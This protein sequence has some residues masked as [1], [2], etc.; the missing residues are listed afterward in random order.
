M[1]ISIFTFVLLL[2]LQNEKFARAVQVDISQY[3]E[4]KFQRAL[5]GNRSIGSQSDEIEEDSSL[6]EIYFWVKAGT[7]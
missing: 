7:L 2:I 3:E 6:A 5:Y 1:K 4:V